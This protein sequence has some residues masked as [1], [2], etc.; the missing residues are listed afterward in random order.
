MSQLV[1]PPYMKAWGGLS[2]E[3]WAHHTHPEEEAGGLCGLG[4]L[5]SEPEEIAPWEG[6]A[7]PVSLN[8]NKVPY[9]IF[10]TC[11]H[12][13]KHSLPYLYLPILLNI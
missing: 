6:N 2:P 1:V 4:P 10:L 12:H 8:L 13:L 5:Q 3:S 11:C 9:P 7:D